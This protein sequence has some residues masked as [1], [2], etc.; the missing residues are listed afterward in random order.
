MNHLMSIRTNIIYSKNKKGNI[1]EP[2]NF[3]KFQEL[4]FLINKPSYRVSN[5][6]EIIRERNIEELRFVVSEKN[7]DTMM[8]LLNKLKIAEE[9][10]LS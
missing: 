6:S 4:I 2:D 10:D 8:D 1:N 5:E 7:F 3:V 9:S